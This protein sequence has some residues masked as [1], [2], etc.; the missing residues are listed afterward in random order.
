[1]DKSRTFLKGKKC[2]KSS[3]VFDVLGDLDELNAALGVARSKASKN[4][5]QQIFQIQNDLIQIGG[6]LATGQKIDLAKKTIFLKKEIKKIANPAIK[7]FSRPGKNQISAFL[8]L[9][10]SFCRRLERRVIG[11][12]KKNFKV[13]VFF[14][15]S[16]SNFIFWLAIKEEKK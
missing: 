14:L 8:H 1:M 12:K 5:N 13:L 6:F 7:T 15:D 16:L 2:L 9:A 10:R 11:L 3:S 4:L